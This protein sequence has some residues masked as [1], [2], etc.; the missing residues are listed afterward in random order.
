MQVSIPNAVPIHGS[1]N[2]E[3]A[4][5]SDIG[6]IRQNN[7]DYC[8]YVQPGTP[9]QAQSH[10]WLFAIADGV[11][12]QQFG[13]VAS[14]TAVESALANFSRSVG[15]ESHTALLRRLIQAANHAVYETAFS[16][17]PG[18]VAMATTIVACT[19][20]YDRVVIAHVGD[21][22]CYLI[23]NGHATA[24]TRDHT[25][26]SEQ[27]RLGMITAKEA[28]ESRNRNLLTRSLGNDL[29][30]AVETGDHLLL[31]DDLLLLC[32][33]GLHNSVHSSDIARLL[34]PGVDLHAGAK[35]LIA[36]ANERDGADN[37]TVQ[38]ICV[39]SVER[40]GLYRGRRYRLR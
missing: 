14:R 39:R 29:F 25:V 5:L 9:L 36:L 11:G 37:I 15:G 38:V 35:R 20:R 18:G 32:S 27:V 7:E 40:T 30:V 6:R 28:A 3:F 10:G 16:A 22:R 2:V 24:L 19:L 12:G 4:Q 33:D 17:S 13:E 1:L 34:A 23:R 8:G 26:S 31:P 21:S